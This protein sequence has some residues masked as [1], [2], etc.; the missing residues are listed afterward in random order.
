MRA[1]WV[2][3]S[4]EDAEESALEAVR[5]FMDTVDA[6]FPADGEE[7]P[8]RK[9]IDSTFKTT[10]QLVGTSNQLARKVV[11]VTEGALGEYER[12]RPSS[13]KS[14]PAI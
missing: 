10:E 11:N 2:I 4:V 14:Q 7:G 1:L 13:E 6:V 5:K 3:D 9:I 12:N 8:R